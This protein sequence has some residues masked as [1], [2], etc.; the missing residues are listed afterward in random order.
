MRRLLPPSDP[1]ADNAVRPARSIAQGFRSH[2]VDT[3]QANAIPQ[4]IAPSISNCGQDA[5]GAGEMA[6][7]VQTE[8]R[9]RHR[10]PAV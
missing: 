2:G 6:T 5:D 8:K 10:Q 4:R 9:S 1:T 7:L 3:A